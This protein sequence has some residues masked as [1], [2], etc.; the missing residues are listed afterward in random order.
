MSCWPNCR[1][2]CTNERKTRI[3]SWRMF[4]RN[5][6]LI[7]LDSDGETP[8]TRLSESL[9]DNCVANNRVAPHR[10]SAIWTNWGVPTA[11]R[12]GS[13]DDEDEE[14]D[15]LFGCALDD[16]R[17]FCG[18]P[19]PAAV[20]PAASRSFLPS[21][22]LFSSCAAHSPDGD[23]REVGLLTRRPPKAAPHTAHTAPRASATGAPHTVAAHL[24]QSKLKATSPHCL[25]RPCTGL[26]G[27]DPKRFTNVPRGMEML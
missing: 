27:L 15:L 6:P 11:D 13:E 22:W 5:E 7:Y 8:R 4:V 26:R 23:M 24:S 25:G 2:C 14:D 12:T 9:S 20:Q 18:S 3:F 10:A 1:G 16:S 19:A 21:Q 17:F